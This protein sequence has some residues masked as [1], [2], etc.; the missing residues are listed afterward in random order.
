MRQGLAEGGAAIEI[1]EFLFLLAEVE[2][3]AGVP[4]DELVGLRLRVD[5]GLDRGVA[6]QGAAE[7]C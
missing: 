1:T 2:E 3:F 5:H 6:W 4:E 7:G